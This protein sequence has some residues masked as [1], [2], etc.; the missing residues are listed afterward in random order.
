MEP[1]QPTVTE[2]NIQVT[3]SVQPSK[4]PVT[5]SLLV[6]CLVFFLPFVEI[7]C[8]GAPLAQ[9]SGIDLAMGFNMKPAGSLTTLSDFGNPVTGQSGANTSSKKQEPNKFAIAALAL[10]IFGVVLAFATKPG[11]K[12]PGII[13]ILAIAALIALMVDVKM[14][15]AD[16]ALKEPDNT[17]IKITVDFTIWYFVSLLSFLVAAVVSLRKRKV[18][19]TTTQAAAVPVTSSNISPADETKA[20][21]GGVVGN[22]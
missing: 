6:A 19:Q 13:A 11:N 3:N 14:H 16:E 10:G 17:G 7:K 18:L 5:I 4:L 22:K 21:E 15:V 8:N 2:Q 9:A 20:G 1:N 12:L